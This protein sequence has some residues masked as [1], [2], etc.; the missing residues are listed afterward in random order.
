MQEL[1]APTASCCGQP[2]RLRAGA[3][4]LADAATPTGCH[5]QVVRVAHSLREL[6]LDFLRRRGHGCPSHRSAFG[7]GQ[8]RRSPLRPGPLHGQRCLTRG[9]RRAAGGGLQRGVDAVFEPMVLHE[10]LHGGAMRTRPRACSRHEVLG[11]G[12]RLQ[13]IAP[14]QGCPQRRPDAIPG[15]AF[16]EPERQGKAKNDVGDN[17][18]SPD[19][20]RR[21]ATF[22]PIL[23]RHV[24]GRACSRQLDELPQTVAGCRFLQY[25]RQAEVE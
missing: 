13:P 4:A 14:S 12:R 3:K 8:C 24:H 1:A 23:R 17:A 20:G 2:T 16:L 18:H 19:V 7:A 9:A 25:P 15:V 21:P 6:L 10:L 5:R 11:V 22:E